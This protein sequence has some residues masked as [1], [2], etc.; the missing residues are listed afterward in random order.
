[1]RSARAP[2]V[3]LDQRFTDMDECGRHLD[4]SFDFRQLDRGRLDVGATLLATAA[5]S[6][7]MRLEMSRAFHQTGSPP[8]GR[9]TFGFPELHAGEFGW[10]GATTAG[11]DLLNFNLPGGFDGTSPAGFSGYTLSFTEDR[12]REVQQI[13]GIDLDSR[14]RVSQHPVWTNS[15]EVITRL[16][17]EM[18]AAIRGARA[19]HGFADPEAS[20]FLDFLAPALILKTITGNDGG[21][22]VPELP[23]RRRAAD[24][25]VEFLDAHDHLPLTVSELC[26]R[27]GVSAPSLYRGF[28]E[29]F[30][31]GPKQ[32]LHVR[33]L[34]GAR[35]ALRSAPPDA[36][37]VDIANG[38]GFWHMG[39]FAA[40]YRRQFGELPS[41]TLHG[42]KAS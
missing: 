32:Y 20:E 30:G 19:G 3:L 5:G 28:M 11:S 8:D 14:V 38:W 1:M 9:L 39:R 12:M 26:R 42:V 21:D 18:A 29:R 24:A 41:R 35:R 15:P 7:G 4:W 10:C 34:A 2:Q 27:A 22:G 37:V 13:M 16:R 33:R 40:E 6:I 31:I 17:H 36:R 23:L 25:A